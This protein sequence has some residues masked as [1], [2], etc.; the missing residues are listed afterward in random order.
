MKNRLPLKHRV[1][2]GIAAIG[3][4]VM[5]SPV[6][7]QKDASQLL[8]DMETK[9]RDYGTRILTIVQY[10]CGAAAAVTLIMLLVEMNKTNSQNKDAIIR[11]FSSFLL[12][13]IAIALVKSFVF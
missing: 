6:F 9:S 8:V 2:L 1:V 13:F 7:A 3:N 12:V 10:V 4:L 11:W 5:S